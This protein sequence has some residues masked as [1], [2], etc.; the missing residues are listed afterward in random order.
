MDTS[1][2]RR[3][4][5]GLVLAALGLVGCGEKAPA[6]KAKIP[7]LDMGAPGTSWADKS[8]EQRLGF[9]AGVVH[10]RMKKLF[11]EYDDGSYDG[12]ACETCHGSKME[13]VDYKMPTDYIMGLSRE[14]TLEASREYDEKVT[15]F[16]VSKVLPELKKMLNSGAGPETKVSCF[17]CHPEE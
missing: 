14:N 15:D 4:T 16:M 8:R 5:T 7:E 11:V 2:L 9:M 3:A 12:F 13:F 17:S 1:T 10:P 6:A